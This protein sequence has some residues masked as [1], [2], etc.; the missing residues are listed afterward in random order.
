MDLKNTN[1]KV[2]VAATE[3]DSSYDRK[4]ELKA[5][6]ESK[7]GVRGLVE[8]GVNKIPLMFHSNNLVDT[9]ENSESD[10][11]FSVPI[12]DL[13][14]I[15]NN[16]KLHTQVVAQI[17]SACCECG[18]FQI[19]NHGIPIS[20]MEGMIGGI[21]RFH[22][23]DVD[24]R[25]KFYTRDLEKRFVYYSNTSLFRDKFANWRDTIGCSMAPDPPKPE[26][27]PEVCRDIMIEYTKKIRELGFTV[28]ELLSE[29]LG[30]NRSYLEELG[31]AEGLF[32]QGHYYP[33]CPEPELTMGTSKHTDSAFLN[34]LLQDQVGGLQV[35][36]ENKWFHVPPVYG[37]FVVNIGDVLQLITN[38]SF[39]SVYHRVLSSKGPRA[40]VSSFFMNMQDP[41][42]Y[43]PIKEMLSEQNP[44]I[45]RD[46]S[47]K[48]FMAHHFAKGLDGNSA[49]H[50]FRL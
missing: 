10:F 1:Q 8:S 35:L 33:A 12:I 39:K 23:Q 43:G 20:T 25:K 16:P 32:I 37:A 49:L 38:D 18:F 41:K 7:A 29:A 13:K 24:V 28:F 30:L 27:L 48:D 6:D 9:I 46:I 22:E 3:S 2:V 40:S 31:C 36:H 5:F 34:I 21:R 14:D 11:K 45:Y 17:R 26:V 50:P 19:I 47:I 15:Q 42:V 44:P 4:A